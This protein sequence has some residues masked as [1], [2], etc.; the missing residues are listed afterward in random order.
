MRERERER[1]WRLEKRRSIRVLHFRSTEYKWLW[2]KGVR[3]F[4]K[5]KYV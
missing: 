4:R 5:S 2:D 3:G 1:M